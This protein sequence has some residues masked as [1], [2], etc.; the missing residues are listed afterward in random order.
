[1]DEQSSKFWENIKRLIREV[2]KTVFMG[3][4]SAVDESERT[5][6]LKVGNVEYEDVRLYG[7]V[8]ADLKGF[9]MLPAVGSSVVVGR[10]EDSN[11]LVVLMCSE[12]DKILYTVGD[13]EI[14]ADAEKLEYKNGD[15]LVKATAQKIEISATEIVMN[16]GDLGGLVKI[17]ELKKSFESL[18][19]YVEAIHSAIPSALTAIGA[20]LASSGAAG[21]TSYT[22]SMA[23][24]MITIE[25]M[26]N[27][28]ITQG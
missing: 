4:V 24:K 3:T 23:G 10:I 26:E 6:V 16:G 7:V 13:V 25:D 27:T 8:K 18:K 12:V 15:T 2:D 22:G 11:E 1:M 20:A 28:N 5:C 19:S 14:L 21:S 9:V 17:E